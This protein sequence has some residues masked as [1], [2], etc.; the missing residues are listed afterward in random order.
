MTT[1]RWLA[2][3]LLCT[4]MGA[5]ATS[6]RQWPRDDLL[7]NSRYQ[8]ANGRFVLVVREDPVVGDF[9]SVRA[10]AGTDFDSEDGLELPSEGERETETAALY[11]VTPRERMLVS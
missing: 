9:A 10:D 1:R 5:N 8:S 11:E 6:L 3:V 7:E 2:L 4:A